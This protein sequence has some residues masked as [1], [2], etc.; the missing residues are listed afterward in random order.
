MMN[1]KNLHPRPL[2]TIDYLELAS[3]KQRE[4]VAQRSRA[5]S[6]RESARTFRAGAAS[7]GGRISRLG[8]RQIAKKGAAANN[9]T[10]GV[11]KTR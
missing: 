10:A 8:T 9:R 1:L 2:M 7:G 6:S 11:T 5:I 4:E 3:V